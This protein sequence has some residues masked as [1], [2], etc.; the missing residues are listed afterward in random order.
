MFIGLFM[1]R[2]PQWA[3]AS[4]LVRLRDNIQLDT[5][6][7]THTSQDSP[8]RVIGPSQGNLLEKT[9]F[10]R[11]KDIHALGGTR[12]HINTTCQSITQHFI[13]C[14]IKIVYCQGDNILFLFHTK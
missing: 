9:P 4:S 10:T 6:T 12:T 3:R 14:A 2:Q 5:H 1:A 11:Q 8:G 7:H 13:L